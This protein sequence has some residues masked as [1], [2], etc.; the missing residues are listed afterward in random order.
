[1]NHP[2]NHHE[3]RIIK[4][5]IV[6]FWTM[7]WLFNVV[8]KFIGGSI[9]LFVGKDR[10]A[11]V[12]KFFFSLGVENP[13]IPLGA[14]AIGTILEI[15]AFVLLAGALWAL[16]RRNDERARTLFFWGTFAGLALFSFFAIGDQIFGD[17]FELLEHT[18]FW[19]AIVISWGAYIYFPREELPSRSLGALS[20]KKLLGITFIILLIS[21]AAVFTMATSSLREFSE[22]PR[23]VQP[24]ELGQGV[25]SFELPFLSKR[26]VWENSL[27]EFINK[28]PELRITAIQTIPSELKSTADNV[29]I[30]VITEK[31]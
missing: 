23:V 16:L 19:I 8:D 4:F 9:F 2:N 25:Y 1:M 5:G 18:L 7:F 30:F 14:L 22:T 28:H 6:I 20:S 15:A 13:I 17:R 26:N 24:K 31:K 11:Q 12:A 21:L 27:T 29:V 3:G 10:F